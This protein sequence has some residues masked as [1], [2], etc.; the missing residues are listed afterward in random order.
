MA[1]SKETLIVLAKNDMFEL[2]TPK[3]KLWSKL[4]NR[5]PMKYW[6]RIGDFTEETDL[7]DGCKYILTLD[8]NYSSLDYESIPVKS[9]TEAIEF[10]KLATKRRN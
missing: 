4:L 5:L 1:Y 2:L 6:D 10:I 7:I 3:G 9:V 8:D